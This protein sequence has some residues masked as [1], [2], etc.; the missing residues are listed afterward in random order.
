MTQIAGQAVV[1]M[2]RIR[3]LWG[4]VEE[5]PQHIQDLLDRLDLLIPLLQEIDNHFSSPDIPPEILNNL[6]LRS[7]M[8]YCQKAAAELQSL[9]VDMNQEI[10]QPRKM[11]RRLASFKVVLN[12]DTVK[13]L[14]HKLA[15]AIE[16][17]VMA[18][19]IFN[20]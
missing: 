16:T 10:T 8:M 6:A 3:Q 18:E 2:V 11:K 5:V 13:R 12:M 15:H 14:E 9:A 20:M 4:K 19:R 1:A 17:V 7:S